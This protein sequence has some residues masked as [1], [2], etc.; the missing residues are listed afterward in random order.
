ME[1]KKSFITHNNNAA[2]SNSS[3]IKG[4]QLF[5]ADLRSTQQSEEQE[6]RIQAEI[7]KIKQHFNSK[8]H[9][10]KLGGYQRKKYIAKLAYV[11]I[12]SNTTKLNDIL[13]GLDQTV[14]LL[15]SNVFS[16]KL[17][18]YMTLELLYEHR[19]VIEKINDKVEYQLNKDLVGNNDNFTSLALNFIGVVGLLSSQMGFN[20]ELVSNVFQILRSPTSS[21]NL[22]KKSALAFLTL[23]KANPA[24]L[25]E[26]SQRKQLWI[27]RITNLLDDT[28]NYRLTL[29]ILPLVEFI[30]RNIDPNCCTRLL[31]QLTQILYDCVVLGTSSSRVNQFP[32][33][34]KFANIP[35]PWLITKIVSL[36]SLMIMSPNESDTNV[37]NTAMLHTDNIEPEILN[38][39]RSCVTEA[40]KLGTKA[41]NDPMERIVQNT[42]L[43]SLINFAS[44]LDPSP[45]AIKNSVVAL[46]SLLSSPEINVRYLTLDSLVKLCSLSGKPAIDAVRYDNLNI[47]LNL[48][49]HE[50]DASII[51]KIVDLL[52]TFTD[53]DNVKLIVDQLL[54]F[55]TN[56]KHVN[57][58]HIK[59]DIAVKIAILTEKYA[60][61][62]N[63]FV[64]ISLKILSLTTSSAS[65]NDDEIWQRLC[66]IVVNN[67]YLQKITCEKLLDYLYENEV[68]ESIIKTSAFL[69]G[70]YANQITDSV[71]IPELFNLFTDKYFIVSNLTKAMIL[72]I[73]VKLYIFAPEIGSAVIKF[74]Q[75]ELNSLDIEL[76]TRSF[77]YL[78]LI[79]LAKVNGGDINLLRTLFAPIPPFNTKANPLLKRLGSLP[80]TAG[81]TLA[82]ATPPSSSSPLPSD[83]TA[84]TTVLTPS[85][86]MPPIAPVSRMNT[87]KTQ[88]QYYSEQI[89]SPNWKEGFVRMILHKQGILQSTPLIKI[90]YRITAPDPTQLS[91]LRISLTFINQTEWDITGLSTEII[92]HRIQDNPEYVITKK[93]IP[94]NA[95]IQP[96]KRSE[97]S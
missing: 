93:E 89:L 60:T 70:E 72:T 51:R 6:K 28:Q 15:K 52:Y 2:S 92:P 29:T 62:P 75:L 69:L 47:I 42:V 5:I 25:T 26:D 10:D 14:E 78:K 34:Y 4:L 23:L 22:K 17:M 76:Q 43:F 82:E 9:H 59:S 38:K 63:W 50:R 16:E 39:L 73:M 58:P 80:S 44:K 21:Q 81:N 97:Q 46:C 85:N 31:P 24:I 27:Q 40:I 30:T 88:E 18:G 48:L 65:F 19:N 3:N 84:S 94:S 83:T 57:D 49:K 77:E 37:Q 32:L 13:F 79:Q 90:I 86:K 8:D 71:S 55:V 64:I 74:L 33:E 91:E 41:C 53:S 1:R 54:N 56:S 35:N 45:E 66:Q 61:D 67:P 36:L 96:Q 20:E 12:T 68:S 87:Q 7:V 95:S 11:Y